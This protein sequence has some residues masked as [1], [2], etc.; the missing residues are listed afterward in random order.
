MTSKRKTDAALWFHQAG[1]DLKASRWN[2]QGGFHD[3]ACFLA[4]QAGEKALKSLLYYLGAR[5][6]ALFTHSLVE[7]VQEAGK[8]VDTLTGLLEDAR[9][10]DLHY[11]PLPLSKRSPQRIP[12][13]VLWEGNGGEGG[14][15]GRQNPCRCDRLLSDRKGGRY[16]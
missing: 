4:Q 7:M 10:L 6:A 11:N 3:T 13:Q 5:R 9:G 2:I 16:P 14:W 8:K 12:A 15:S 1:Y